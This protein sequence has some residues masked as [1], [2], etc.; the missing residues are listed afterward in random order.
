MCLFY[1]ANLPSSAAY[2][3]SLESVALLLERGAKVRSVSLFFSLF[4]LPTCSLSH[5]ISLSCPI[6]FL[7]ILTLLL[8]VTKTKK[9]FN[10]PLLYLARTRVT[11][12]NVALFGRVVD[13]LV[14]GGRLCFFRVLSLPLRQS[15]LFLLFILS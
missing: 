3:C 4:A 10:T 1:F 11:S 5:F 12:D 9:D 2:G 6:L 14:Q 15:S 13:Q 7:C 8:Q